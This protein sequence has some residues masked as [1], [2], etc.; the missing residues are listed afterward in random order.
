M[1]SDPGTEVGTDLGTDLVGAKEVN[2]E[3]G[4][5]K[6]KKCSMGRGRTAR[7]GKATS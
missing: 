4:K 6:A 7:G 5:R 3:S 2:S 1:G